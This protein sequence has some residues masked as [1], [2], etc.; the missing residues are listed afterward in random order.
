MNNIAIIEYLIDYSQEEYKV[1]S[2]SFY[3][4]EI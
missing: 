1:S 4:F 3:L 2:V